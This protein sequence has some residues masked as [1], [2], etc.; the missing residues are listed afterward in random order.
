MYEKINKISIV[1]SEKC[2]LKFPRCVKTQH[3]LH[4]IFNKKIHSVQNNIGKDHTKFQLSTSQNV[5]VMNIN[6]R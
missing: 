1:V 5:D 6:P 4:I 2:T 3:G